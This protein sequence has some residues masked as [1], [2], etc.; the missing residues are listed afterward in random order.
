MKIRAVFR[1]GFLTGLICSIILL[2]GAKAGTPKKLVFQKEDSVSNYRMLNSPNDRP[3]PAL[4]VAGIVTMKEA[5]RRLN[6][7]AFYTNRDGSQL[8][9]HLVNWYRYN[10][11]D[12]TKTLFWNGDAGHGKDTVV[13]NGKPL[14]GYYSC[15]DPMYINWVLSFSK[16]LGIDE[17]NVDY[18]GGVDYP[19]EYIAYYKIRPWDSWF[20]DLLNRAEK[21][22]VKI[23]VM[24][25][26]KSIAG[27]LSFYNG[28]KAEL[29]LNEPAYTQ[30]VLEMLKDDLRKICDRFTITKDENNKYIPNPAY[31][32]VAGLPVIWVFG[33]SASGLDRKSVV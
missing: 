33:M 29:D 7:I 10:P 28:G 21:F 8:I 23:S 4:N 17:L 1:D 12:M 16:A 9:V 14:F 11:E 20:I 6:N 27:R 25:E 24:Y 19:K 15:N 30:E 3:A 31:K 5:I 26:P 13:L 22:N 2:S 18:E 32:R